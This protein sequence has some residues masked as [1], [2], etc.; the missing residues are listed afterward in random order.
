MRMPE[1]VSHK[2]VFQLLVYKYKKIFFLA[3]ICY[4]KTKLTLVLNIKKGQNFKAILKY[5]W[6]RI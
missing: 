6:E 1:N 3:Y 4:N 5:D 2:I